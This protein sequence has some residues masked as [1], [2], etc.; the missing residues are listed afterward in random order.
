MKRFDER[1][2]SPLR[3]QLFSR[4][5]WSQDTVMNFIHLLLEKTCRP[6]PVEDVSVVDAGF[7]SLLVDSTG[8]IASRSL[9]VM[10]DYLSSSRLLLLPLQSQDHWS[11]LVFAIGEKTWYH[12]DSLG[13]FHRDRVAFVLARLQFI[14]VLD[15]AEHQLVTFPSLPR[16][17]NQVESGS[18]VV[19]YAF[20]FIFNIIQED[21]DSDI[22]RRRISKQLPM[23]SEA[24]RPEFLSHLETII[25]HCPRHQ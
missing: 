19:F 3:G 1:K 25:A 20:I 5:K 4:E 22:F 12:C 11:L 15:S 23:I 10:R 8:P 24:R 16:Q 17:E 9:Q 2:L 13:D 18:F 7:L 21:C 14:R 6:I